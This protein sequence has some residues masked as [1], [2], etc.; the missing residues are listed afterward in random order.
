MIIYCDIFGN[1]DPFFN[2]A[3]SNKRVYLTDE[4]YLKGF[5]WSRLKEIIILN[6]KQGWEN[7]VK[8]LKRKVILLNNYI[9]SR[10]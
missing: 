3:S 4:K 2:Y 7:F 10:T 5:F 9:N 1:Y 8:N 6:H